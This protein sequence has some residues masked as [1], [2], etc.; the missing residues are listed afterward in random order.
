[1]FCPFSREKNWHEPRKVY[2]TWQVATVRSINHNVG[3]LKRAELPDVNTGEQSSDTKR[4]NSLCI[5]SVR[6]SASQV[7]EVERVFVVAK[8]ELND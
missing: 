1:M 7:F 3:A 2:W 5:K 8:A 4:A 6:Y